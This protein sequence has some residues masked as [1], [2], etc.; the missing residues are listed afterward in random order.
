MNITNVI[1]SKRLF[2]FG[3]FSNDHHLPGFLFVVWI[4]GYPA[5]ERWDIKKKHPGHSWSFR[6]LFGVGSSG[7]LGQSRLSRHK[8]HVSPG[9]DRQCVTL[10]RCRGTLL[11]YLEAPQSSIGVGDV[12]FGTRQNAHPFSGGVWGLRPFTQMMKLDEI[13]IQAHGFAILN[14]IAKSS[15]LINWRFSYYWHRF[16][17]ISVYI[18]IYLSIFPIHRLVEGWVTP[19]R[20]IQWLNIALF[21]PKLPQKN[22]LFVGWIQIVVFFFEHQQFWVDFLH[23]FIRIAGLLQGF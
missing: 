17:M 4:G 21:P 22:A 11:E 12:G 19:F 5:Q 3:E 23:L 6:A 20:S 9:D 13:G 16:Q 8:S 18:M 14:Q 7:P 10:Q 2:R 15:S 1:S